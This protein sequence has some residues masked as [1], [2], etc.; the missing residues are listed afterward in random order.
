[1][2]V[3]PYPVAA[4]WIRIDGGI[5]RDRRPCHGDRVDRPPAIRNVGPDRRRNA[6]VTAN[7]PIDAGSCPHLQ[8]WYLATKTIPPPY[9]FMRAD[10]GIRSPYGPRP[11]IGSGLGVKRG[12]CHHA[13]SPFRETPGLSSWPRP[14]RAT[15][16]TGGSSDSR[17]SGMSLR[18][19]GACPPIPRAIAQRVP[20]TSSPIPQA[21]H[22]QF[23]TCVRRGPRCRSPYPF[24]TRGPRSG[25]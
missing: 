4:Q 7:R 6:R 25:T 19:S 1:M 20:K 9:Q 22:E 12:K 24:W 14:L 16:M 5:R 3:V 15:P 2:H 17:Q 18:G 21:Y 23:P 8:N 11:V 10:I 13:K